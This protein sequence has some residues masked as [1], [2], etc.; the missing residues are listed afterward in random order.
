[1]TASEITVVSIRSRAPIVPSIRRAGVDPDAD[2]DRRLA[3]SP[4]RSRLKSLEPPEHI[5]APPAG[6][7]R[8]F[9]EQ[10]HH[11]VADKLV[12]HAV[13]ARDGRLHRAQ[14]LID[15]FERL[16]RRHLLG[17]AREVADVGEQHGHDALHLIAE[18][19]VGDA[20]LAELLQEL[21]RH[22]ARIAVADLGQ[23]Q[24]HVDPGQQLIAG[25]RLGQVVVGAGAEAADQIRDA[26]LGG[27][28]D[29]RQFRGR[30]PLPDSLADLEPGDP[31]AS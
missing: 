14:I 26:V 22:E 20:L 6:V 1:M 19:D 5:Q 11:G 29:D 17:E 23:L 3:A 21:A 18:R 31:A 27:Q 28:Q 15:E 25:E 13:V 30:M 16:G 12:D 10:R 8:R 2:L 4:A 24:M 9:G 7:V